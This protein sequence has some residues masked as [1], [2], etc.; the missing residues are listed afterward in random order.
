[1]AWREPSCTPKHQTCN[2]L[3]MV[4][5]AGVCGS[6]VVNTGQKKWYPTK[7]G[8]KGETNTKKRLPNQGLP[9][10]YSKDPN[11]TKFKFALWE[12]GS[13]RDFCFFFMSTC[14][15]TFYSVLHLNQYNPMQLHRTCD[16]AVS[17]MAGRSVDRFPSQQCW[18][19]LISLCKSCVCVCVCVQYAWYQLYIPSCNCSQNC[20]HKRSHNYYSRL[21]HLTYHSYEHM[22]PCVLSFIVT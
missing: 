1:M 10:T 4:L 21:F 12:S 2:A 11:L 8:K 5:W 15:Y 20:S 6:C 13:E 14:L 17:I 3:W 22:W 16:P 18:S 19:D 7:H 9:R